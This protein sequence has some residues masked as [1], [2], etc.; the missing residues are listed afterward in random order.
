MLLPTFR[1]H[2]SP[3]QGRRQRKVSGRDKTKK[4]ENY[5]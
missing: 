2:T 5:G 4:F 3:I 1:L